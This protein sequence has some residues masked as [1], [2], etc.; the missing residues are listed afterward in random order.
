MKT[1]MAIY[2]KNRRAK[3]RQHLIDSAG[4]KCQVCGSTESLEFDH[5]DRNTKLFILSGKALDKPMQVIEAEAAKCD[6][7]C[8]TCH[9]AKTK[10]AGD[11]I[12]WRKPAK[13]CECGTPRGY[14]G[15]CRCDACKI[16][17]RQYRASMIGFTDQFINILE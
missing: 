7:L 5:R 6:L 9:L 4:G 12:V 8:N 16:A 17:K 11:N 10:T 2:M 15:G 1:D 14:W 13:D 3:R